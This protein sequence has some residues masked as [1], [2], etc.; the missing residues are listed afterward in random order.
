MAALAYTLPADNALSNAVVAA[1]SLAYTG[2]ATATHGLLS[3][4]LA[5]TYFLTANFKPLL[6][7]VVFNHTSPEAVAVGI[8]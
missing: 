8:S 6:G 5:L 2:V 3:G 4:T 1:E 7:L